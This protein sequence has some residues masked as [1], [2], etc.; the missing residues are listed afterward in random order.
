[1]DGLAIGVDVWFFNP[2]L[3]RARLENGFA[4][5]TACA[6]ALGVT[7]KFE[8]GLH[9]GFEALFPVELRH[10]IDASHGLL[11]RVSLIREVPLHEAL[12]LMMDSQE[13]EDLDRRAHLQQLV[14]Q[15]LDTLTE[16]ERDILKRR[17][18]MGDYDPQTL[19][20]IGLH[21]AVE[22]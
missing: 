19:E 15:T 1:M 10:A 9:R 22:S 11:S 13:V 2:Y 18:G 21:Q 7:L 6:A 3:R 16:R 14:A 8:R 4:T 5:C 12:P 17:F 20:Q